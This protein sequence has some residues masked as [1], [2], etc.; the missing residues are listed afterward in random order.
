VRAPRPAQGRACCRGGL[1]PGHIVVSTPLLQVDDLRVEYAR[2]AVW[3]SR[4]GAGHLAL[5]AVSLAIGEADAL[6]VVGESGSGKSTLARAILRLVR[7]APRR[8]SVCGA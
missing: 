1:P 2:P 3:R 8:P 4:E 6:G 7:H 5:D